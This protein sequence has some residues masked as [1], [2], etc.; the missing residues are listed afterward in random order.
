MTRSTEK[1]RAHS[2]NEGESSE[3]TTLGSALARGLLSLAG[4][5]VGYFAA[6]LLISRSLL[7]GPN[8]LLYLTIVGVL[9][10]YLVSGRVARLR[11]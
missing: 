4:G 7:S 1:D 8:N 6:Q 5:L 9:V 11:L 2:G 3:T 10:G